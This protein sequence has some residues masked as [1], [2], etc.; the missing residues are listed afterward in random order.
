MKRS[1]IAVF[2]AGALLLAG[3]GSGASSSQA[4]VVD[5]VEESAAPPGARPGAPPASDAEVAAARMMWEGIAPNGADYLAQVES[6][7]PL[8]TKDK[9]DAAIAAATGACLTQDEL[10]LD[11]AGEKTGRIFQET[12]G[13][14]LTAEQAEEVTSAAWQTVC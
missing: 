11:A 13:L 6:V 4:E 2:G 8:D 1:V 3:C 7:Y 9:L 5:I 14:A 12:F 10:A